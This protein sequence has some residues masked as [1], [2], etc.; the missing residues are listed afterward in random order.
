MPP[1]VT[2]SRRCPRRPHPFLVVLFSPFNYQL[3]IV[4]LQA[5]QGALTTLLSTAGTAPLMAS[6]GACS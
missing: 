3:T 4:L 2:L 6:T 5:T 1:S